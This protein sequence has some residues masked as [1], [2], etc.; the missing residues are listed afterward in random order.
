MFVACVHLCVCYWVKRM[1]ARGADYL[2]DGFKKKK[3]NMPG[4]QT[5]ERRREKQSRGQQKRRKQRDVWQE[6]QRKKCAW[7]KRRGECKV[8]SCE[9]TGVSVPCGSLTRLL[10]AWP[11]QLKSA[12]EWFWTGDKERGP[13]SFAEGLVFAW[14]AMLN[15]RPGAY[16]LLKNSHRERISE[17]CREYC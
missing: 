8:E 6:A 4:E 10:C 7:R 12:S 2:C 15:F 17:N 5:E 9:W 16:Q 3:E 13:T 11:H 1:G 14:G